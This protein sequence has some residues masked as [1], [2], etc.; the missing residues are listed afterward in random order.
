VAL[1]QRFAGGPK[2]PGLFADPVPVPPGAP[3]FTVLLGRLGRVA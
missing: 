3:P 2:V 1:L